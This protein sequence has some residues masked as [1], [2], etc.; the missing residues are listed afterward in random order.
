MRLPSAVRDREWSTL[1]RYVPFVSLTT[2][3]YYYNITFVQLGLIDLG[4][5]L[6]GVVAI[7]LTIVLVLVSILGV[8]PNSSSSA[9][10]SAPS[11]SRTSAGS[12]SNPPF[13]RPPG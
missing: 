3:G 13:L 11:S 5:R 8:S 10:A 12:A 2:A 1:A 6:L 4:T 9:S 7:A